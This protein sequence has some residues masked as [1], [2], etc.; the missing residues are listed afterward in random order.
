MNQSSLIN[1]DPNEYNEKFCYY[2]FADKQYRYT[3]SCN[4]LI[5]MSSN[6]CVPPKTEDLSLI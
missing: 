2:S 4:T 1:L 3:R 5:Y 6:V